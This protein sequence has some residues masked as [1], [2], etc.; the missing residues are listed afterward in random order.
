MQYKIVFT[1]L[2]GHLETNMSN[3]FFDTISSTGMMVII[4]YIK[5]EE[6][7]ATSA[8][9]FGNRS[10]SENCFGSLLFMLALSDIPSVTQAITLTS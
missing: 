2:L 9:D 1:L 4:D 3:K 8:I 7:D 5:I 6:T 10:T